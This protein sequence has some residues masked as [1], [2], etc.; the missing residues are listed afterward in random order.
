MV[1]P[2]RLLNRKVKSHKGD[3]GKI[4]ILAG[5]LR[6]IGAA[7]L[8]ARACLR[9]GAGLVTLAIPESLYSVFAKRIE[10]L[11]L[12]P[13][14]ETKQRSLS[15]KAFKKVSKL[16]EKTDCLII[17]PGLSDNSS[18]V[19]LIR[20]VL[21]AFDGPMVIDADAINALKGQNALLK[22]LGNRCVLTP[23]AA[24]LSRL[25]AV[26]PSDISKAR[27]KIA[28]QFIL[29]Y[30]VVLVLK[31]HNTIVIDK[32]KC[33]INH[34][35]NPGMATAGS[36]DVLSGIIGSFIGQGLDTFN[37]AKSAVYLHGLLGD[38]AARKKTQLGLIATDLIEE[39]PAA[40]KRSLPA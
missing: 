9:S 25:I 32:S 15:I 19:R 24:E 26:K 23:H 7:L 35:G 33:Y 13:M 11:I 18:T 40:I 5:S 39:I 21:S 10:E 14:E 4:L 3:F 22:K 29:K 36:G 31:G 34:T 37:A 2:A 8:C 1:L 6:Y 28:K 16:L 20:K 12:V 38:I 27:K 17:G 30:N